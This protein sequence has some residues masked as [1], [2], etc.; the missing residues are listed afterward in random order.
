MPRKRPRNPAKRK[1]QEYDAEPSN[2]INKVSK[3]RK[4]GN[5]KSSLEDFD[6]DNGGRT[7]RQFQLMM[8]V[9]EGRKKGEKISSEDNGQEAAGGK[10]KKILENLPA[11]KIQP[12]ERLSE[13]SQRVNDA[14]PLI[15]ARSG[16]P[17]RKDRKRIKKLENIRVQQEQRRQK[18][19]ESGEL[20]ENEETQ[21][22][23]RSQRR[24]HKGKRDKSPDPWAHLEKKPVKF[25]EVADA[26]PDLKLPSKLLSNIPK[27]AGSLA[28]REMLAEERERFI[29]QYRVFMEQ[30]RG[31][32][33]TE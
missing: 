2:N 20:D 22:R 15:K 21:R 28:K 25:G 8:K 13:F 11:L 29:S 26:P 4:K 14:L 23:S 24:H 33:S 12:G 17:S 3:R 16:S 30:K 10:N 1:E 19:I 31:E 6:D 9:M 18:L 27:A 5:V 7:P 32:H